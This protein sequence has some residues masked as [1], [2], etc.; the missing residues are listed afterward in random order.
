MLSNMVNKSQIVNSLKI[1]LLGLAF[2]IYSLNALAAPLELQPNRLD[3]LQPEERRTIS[4]FRQ[5]APSVVYITSIALRRDLFSFNAVEIPQGAGSGVI[6]DRNG[7]ILTNYHVIKD[8]QAAQV[9][10]SDRSTHSASLVGYEID[11]DLAVLKIKPSAKGLKPISLGDSTALLV[12]Q[13][14]LAIGNP[15]GFDHTL[16]SGIISGLGREIE[17]ESGRLIKGVIQTDAAINPGNSGGPLLNSRGE[18]IGINTAIFSPSGA[19]AGIGFAVP[20][21]VVERIVPQLI[22]YGKVAKPGIGV[23]FLDDY[24]ARSFGIKGAIIEDV[25]ED[26]P[27]SRVGLNPTKVDA[28]GQLI[29][30]DIIVQINKERVSSVNNLRDYLEDKKFGEKIEIIFIRGR[31]PKRIKLEII[32]ER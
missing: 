24:I 16:T 25:L 29:L 9:T 18:M 19:Y 2:L 4:L 22:R 3:N 6:W 28:Y 20:I 11:K 1:N 13:S 7:Y 17:A 8:A 12:G 10:L 30:G 31:T 27:A 32:E 23:T 5:T 15:F 14:V 21:S 26:T